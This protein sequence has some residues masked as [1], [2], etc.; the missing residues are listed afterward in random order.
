MKKFI[1]K[2]TSWPTLWK[3]IKSNVKQWLWD[4]VDTVLRAPTRIAWKMW[5]KQSQGNISPKNKGEMSAKN[6]VSRTKSAV[7]AFRKSPK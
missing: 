3:S 4:A 1:K 5:L 7:K 2:L 6:L